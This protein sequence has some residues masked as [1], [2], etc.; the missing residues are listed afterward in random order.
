MRKLL[1]MKVLHEQLISGRW[2]VKEHQALADLVEDVDVV[3]KVIEV[4][5]MGL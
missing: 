5:D 3:G 1:F 2:L 4:K